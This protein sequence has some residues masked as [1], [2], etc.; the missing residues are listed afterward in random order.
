MDS[1]VRDTWFAIRRLTRDRVFAMT[2]IATIALALGATSAIFSVTSAVLLEPL[3]YR[4]PDRLVYVWSDL[5]NRNVTHFQWSPG[6]MYEVKERATLLENLAGVRTME[7]T[8]RSED[9]ETEVVVTAAITPDLLELLGLAVAK[10]RDFGAADATPLPQT[11]AAQPATPPPPLAIV[12][13]H[14]L[15]QRRYGG[16]PA[17]VG[18]MIPWGIGGRAEIVGVLAP[19]AR[20]LFPTQAGIAATADV[21]FTPRFDIVNGN[22]SNVAL[23]TVARVKPGVTLAAAQAQLDA[24]ADDLRRRDAI[25]ATAGLHFRLEPMHAGLTAELRPTILALMASAVVLLAVACANLANLMLLRA[26]SR[27]REFAV[28]AALGGGRRALVR[29]VL[30]DGLLIAGAGAAAGIG[31]AYAGLQV[32]AHLGPENVP[33]LADVAVSWRVLVFTAV[34]AIVSAMVFSVVPAWRLSQ[35]HLMDTL[36]GSGRVTPGGHH[37]HNAMV[38]TQVALSFALLIGSGLMVRSVMTLQNMDPGFEY[39]RVLTFRTQSGQQRSAAEMRTFLDQIAETVGNIPGVEAV[40]AASSLPFDGSAAAARW[41][42]EEALADATRF[43]QMTPHYVRNGYFAAMGT[44]LLAGRDFEPADH[45]PS[46]RVVIIDERVAAKAFAGQPAVGKR[47]LARIGAATEAEWY[48]V[49][50]VVPHQR[51]VSLA[52]DGRE[53]MFFPEGRGGSGAASRWIVRT[54]G[55]PADA[56]PVIQ[57]ALTAIDPTLF[58]PRTEPLRALVDRVIAPARLALVLLGMFAAVAAMLAAVGLYG[59]LASTVAQRRTE[60]GVRRAFGAQSTTIARWFLM[61][62]FA[63]TAGGVVVGLATGM[64]AAHVLMQQMLVGV[65]ALDPW[66]YAGAVLL[67]GTIALIASWLPARRALRVD[68]MVALRET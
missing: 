37:W 26:T 49:V 30:I 32:L 14:G 53:L 1:L 54:A 17:I 22:R 2:A 33:R 58:F 50:G 4:A 42:T 34:V 56:A 64:L 11:T 38:V 9:A 45:V 24:I 57:H 12:I 44:R 8:L 29:L 7:T 55:V 21:Y 46:A 40:S 13:S 16:D 61:R 18:R 31:L 19:G 28:R 59:V 20:L 36:R 35:R 39:D 67:F 65:T 3:P 25:N 10:G 63:L 23:H 47:V 51:R 60:I 27:E 15:W 68:A 43:Q 52:A 62:G 48:E 41:G 66:T 6:D 5:R